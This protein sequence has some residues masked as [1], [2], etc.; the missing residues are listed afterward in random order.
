MQYIPYLI[1]IKYIFKKGY[2]AIKSYFNIAHIKCNSYMR[3]RDA[4]N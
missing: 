4:L 3:M 1:D 2:S